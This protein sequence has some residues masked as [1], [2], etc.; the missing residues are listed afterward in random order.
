MSD[1]RAVE[2][3]FHRGGHERV[4]GELKGFVKTVEGEG[5]LS[6]TIFN[7]SSAIFLALLRCRGLYG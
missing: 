3:G 1:C 2:G 4:G 5:C 7:Q 6:Q